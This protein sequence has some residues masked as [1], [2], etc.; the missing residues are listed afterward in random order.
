MQNLHVIFAVDRAGLVGED[1]ETHHGIYDVGFLRHAPGLKVL[2]PGSRQELQAML[3]WA[4]VEQRGPVAIRYPR[5]GDRD[6]VGSAWNGQDMLYCHRSGE[7]VTILA[8]GTMVR[9]ALD[10]AEI[11][12]QSGI[13]ASVVRLMSVNPLPVEQIS[14]I[15]NKNSPLIIL[16]DSSENCGIK[17]ALAYELHQSCPDMIVKGL[18]LGCCYI[19]HG[20]VDTLHAQ[21][22]LDGRSVAEFVQEVLKD[23]N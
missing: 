21:C 9:N 4:V 15:V 1:G 18:D 13:K 11:L 8:Y 20:A 3:R 10:A 14:G 16:E 2:C 12:F 23:E 22:G 5:G 17:G 19:P 6:Y 7:D